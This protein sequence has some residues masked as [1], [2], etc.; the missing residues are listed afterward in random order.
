MKRK[1]IPSNKYPKFDTDLFQ[2]AD[3]SDE[4]I[5]EL[6]QMALPEQWHYSQKEREGGYPVLCDYLANTF[7][8]LISEKKV[9]IGIFAN[10]YSDA[11]KGIGDH[12]ATINTGLLDKDYL[13]I[14][15]CFKSHNQS[16]SDSKAFWYLAGFFT[17]K[18]RYEVMNFHFNLPTKAD[19]IK[20]DIHNIY[21]NPMDCTLVLDIGRKTDQYKEQ[22][23]KTTFYVDA[24]YTAA[25][26]MYDAVEDKMKFVIPFDEDKDGEV[27]S[28]LVVE[29]FMTMC[30]VEDIYHATD[31]I[32]LEEA[33][34]N[35]RT[36]KRVDS[37]WLKI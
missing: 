34:V 5:A 18:N 35:C 22:F 14:Y 16:E 24:D 6:A 1:P 13:Y 36:V 20:N 19:Y 8:R 17:T 31:I 15:A 28:A 26:P 21:L 32:S 25:V 33:Y 12:Y 23:R 3:I 11:K 37:Q 4:Q 9:Q 7:L 27:D 10:D 29:K 2:W 30:S